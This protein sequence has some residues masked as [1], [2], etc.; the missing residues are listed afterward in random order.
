MII[1]FEDADEL[2][3]RAV[4]D[5]FHFDIAPIQAVVDPSSSL[6]AVLGNARQVHSIF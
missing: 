2:L 6:K 3:E 1:V 5:S 4:P